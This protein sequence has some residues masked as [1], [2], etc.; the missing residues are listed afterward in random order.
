M[1]NHWFITARRKALERRLR[2]LGKMNFVPGKAEANVSHLEEM[3]VE[4]SS[5]PNL[6]P[7]L[8]RPWRRMRVSD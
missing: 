8:P 2:A 6:E 1:S 4:R 3:P 5:V 7:L